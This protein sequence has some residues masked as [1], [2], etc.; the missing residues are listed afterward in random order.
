VCECHIEIK[1]YL[2]T[3]LL[4]AIGWV[5]R[6]RTF[7]FRKGKMELNPLTRTQFKTKSMKLIKIV[8]KLLQV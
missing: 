3:Y 6:L 5:Q 7:I 1:G 4:A 2:L 8:T